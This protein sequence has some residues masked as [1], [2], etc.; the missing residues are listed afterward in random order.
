MEGAVHPAEARLNAEGDACSDRD[1]KADVDRHRAEGD[2]HRPAERILQ[3]QAKRAAQL[4]DGQLHVLVLVVDLPASAE[5]REPADLDLRLHQEGDLVLPV[6]LIGNAE[7]RQ[8][9]REEARFLIVLLC[10]GQVRHLVVFPVELVVLHFVLK[11]LAAHGDGDVPP[12]VDLDLG[13]HFIEGQIDAPVD[14]HSRYLELDREALAKHVV[15]YLP[16]LVDRRVHRALQGLDAG[17]E[18]LVGAFLAE[19]EER[20]LVLGD[21]GLELPFPLAVE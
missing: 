12:Q 10:L 8:L 2:H 21:K 20:R 13:Q 19:G 4:D 6:I 18:V 1:R 15:E 17:L 11:Q 14:V 16:A 5:Q 7:L 9:I 3:R